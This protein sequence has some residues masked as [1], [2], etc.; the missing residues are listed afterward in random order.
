MF[1]KRLIQFVGVITLLVSVVLP[2]QPVLAAGKR[3]PTQVA[4]RIKNFTLPEVNLGRDNT[5]TK[6]VEIIF[7]V[8]EHCQM[9]ETSRRAL[10]YIPPDALQ[11]KPEFSQSVTA[12]STTSSDQETAAVITATTNTAHVKIYQLDCCG[13]H[14]IELQTDHAWTW[15]STTASLSGNGLTTAS[16]CCYWWHLTAGPTM[17]HGT[18]SSSHVYAKGSASYVCYNSGPSPFCVGPTPK[19]PMTFYT[20]LHMYNNGVA[21]A[22]GT[23]Y[24]G[25]V[26]PFGSVVYQFWKT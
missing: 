4:C 10:D 22:S 18:Y 24:S 7:T 5:N 12:S 6:F 19:Y 15:T 9:V 11:N 21:N 23:S 8:N 3:P 26:I 14:T 1:N 17:S 16:W 25:T 2:V 20:W 13:I